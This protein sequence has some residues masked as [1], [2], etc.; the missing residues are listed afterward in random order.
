MSN[1]SDLP[2][3]TNK[4]PI[5]NFIVRFLL[6]ALIAYVLSLLLQPHIVIS[7][8]G[9]ALIF[10][11]I[12]G[13]VNVIVKPILVILTLPITLI[14]LGIFLIVLNVLMIML[15]AKLTNGI[16]IQNFWWALIFGIMLSFFSTAL[17]NWGKTRR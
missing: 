7:S 8:Y 12:L 3:L 15:A 9:A 16:S 17:S 6:T 11:L 2:T 1:F 5:M 10:V 4:L 14:T 13:L